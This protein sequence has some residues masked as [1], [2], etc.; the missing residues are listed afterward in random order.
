VRE[1]DEGMNEIEKWVETADEAKLKESAQ[2]VTLIGTHNAYYIGQIV[3]VR[4]EK[5]SWAPNM[6]VK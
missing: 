3:Y 4:R 2:T 6:G 1:L 5:G